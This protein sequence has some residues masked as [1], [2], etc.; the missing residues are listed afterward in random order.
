[1]LTSSSSAEPKL[2][3]DRLTL[4]CDKSDS[5]IINTTPWNWSICAGEKICIMS[6][7]SFLKVQLMAIISGFVHPISGNFETFGSLSW[8]LGGEG[9]LDSK[10]T[11]GQGFDFVSS[12]Y[13][14][15]LEASLISVDDFFD[16]LQTRSIDSSTRLKDLVKEQK[17][18]FYMMLSILFSFDIYLVTGDRSR[19]LMTREARPLRNLLNK[20]LSSSK[21]MVTISINNRFKREFCNRGI[22]LGPRGETLFYGDLEDAI[23]YEIKNVKIDSG[24]ESEE[25]QFDMTSNLTNSDSSTDQIDVF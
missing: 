13:S 1:M 5:N 17:D 23:D 15:C 20:Q 24:S 2:T 18:F 10:L 16:V 11:I 8:P 7:N 12:I 6:S 14:D 21:S 19:Y 22:V 25:N 4:R 9:G 3:F